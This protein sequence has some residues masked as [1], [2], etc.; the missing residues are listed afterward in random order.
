MLSKKFNLKRV[1]SCVIPF[2]YS[3]I[4]WLRKPQFFNS[5]DIDS[6]RVALIK[7]FRLRL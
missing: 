2:D 4:R 6:N 7:R 5:I 1:Y 3:K